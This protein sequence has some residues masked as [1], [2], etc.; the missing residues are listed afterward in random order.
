[1]ILYKKSKK[2]KNLPKR[3][4]A[5]VM[6]D[7]KKAQTPKEYRAVHKEMKRD[8]GDSVPIWYRYPY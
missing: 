8:F 6:E 3:S 4:Y 5:E 2:N 7:F 1:M